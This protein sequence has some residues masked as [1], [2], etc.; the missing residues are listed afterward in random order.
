G[1]NGYG[2]FVVNDFGLSSQSFEGCKNLIV[3]EDITHNMEFISESKAD[4]AFGSLRNVLPVP[5]GGFVRSMKAIHHLEETTFAEEV[6]LEKLMGM[7]LKKKYLEGSFKEKQVFRELFINAETSFENNETFTSLPSL[8]EKYFFEL[9][10]EK[11]IS[12]KKNN[13]FL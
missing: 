5:V 1:I 8:I 10:T 4:Y 2:L 13:S 12:L 7:V 3:I 9:D 11:I 6:A